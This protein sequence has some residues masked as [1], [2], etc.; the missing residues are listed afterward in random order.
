MR[1]IVKLTV[2]LTVFS[3][4]AAAAIAAVYSATK[5]KIAA[6]EAADREIAL[7]S[8]FPEGTQIQPQQGSDSLPPV[9]WE[10]IK[11]GKRIGLAFQIE[12]RGYSSTVKFIIAVDEEGSI[13]GLT[14][15]SQNETPG[16]G[17]RMQEVLSKST[18]WT[19]WR[20]TE[21][22]GTPW[23]TG[24][25]KGLS[26]INPIAIY[27]SGEWHT[28]DENSRAGFRSRNAI[29]AITGATI[30]TKAVAGGIESEIAKYLN[31]IEKE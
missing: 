2:I 30:S 11:E 29:S 14:V 16:L 21:K 18:L 26:A 25:F 12:R 10:G 23:F 20:R 4:V 28:L 7:G 31:A 3:A 24:Q 17:S 15:L 27:K 19:A 13:L 6:Q 1:D 9:Y 8:V 5:E 22:K